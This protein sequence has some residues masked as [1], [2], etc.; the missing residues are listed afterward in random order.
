MRA[1]LIFAYGIACGAL[2]MAMLPHA[3]A[4]L[5][6]RSRFLQSTS[7]GNAGAA[8]AHTAEKFGFVANGMMEEVAPLFGAEKERVWSPG[9]NP[10]FV[11]PVPAKDELGMVFIAA[12]SHFQAVWVN[13]EFDLKKGRI[14]YAYMIPETM[15]SLITLRLTPQGPQTRVEVEYDRTSLSTEANGQ[16][17]S[18]AEQD[19]VAGPEW[20]KQVNEFLASRVPPSK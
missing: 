15:V 3:A 7:A 20:E 18:M 4:H 6:A 12:H 9:W 10:Q 8:R 2:V 16:V 17:R 1:A 14:Q 5:R 19:H 13:T 11:H